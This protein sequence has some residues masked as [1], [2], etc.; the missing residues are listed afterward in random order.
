MLKRLFVCLSTHPKQFTCVDVGFHFNFFV[1]EGRR[2]MSVWI[3]VNL[4]RVGGVGGS[5]VL[6]FLSNSQGT[7]AFF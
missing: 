4:F 7:N 6:K 1:W 5:F 2:L 3:L